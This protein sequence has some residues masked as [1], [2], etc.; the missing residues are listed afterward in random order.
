[1]VTGGDG[2]S[3]VA[4]IDANTCGYAGKDGTYDQ[5]ADPLVIRCLFIREEELWTLWTTSK[6]LVLILDAHHLSLRSIMS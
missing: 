5:R 6:S 1:M 2:I 4:L 3:G